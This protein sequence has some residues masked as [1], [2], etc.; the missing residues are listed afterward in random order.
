M[1]K[2]LNKAELDSHI[3]TIEGLV[4]DAGISVDIWLR[5][6]PIPN[7]IEID[8][9][10]DD[11]TRIQIT[12]GKVQIVATGSI[13]VFRRSNTMRPLTL[14]QG[15]SDWRLLGKYLNVSP[16]DLHLLVAW[17]AYTIGQPRTADAKYV[18]LVLQGGEGTGK[19]TLCKLITQIID[20]STLG[21]RKLPANEKDLAIATQAAHLLCFDNMRILTLAM[22]DAICV[23][24]TGG[25]I[26]SRQLYTDD[27]EHAL[28]LHG[29]L[30]LNGIHQFVDQPDLAQRCLPLR[31]MPIDR[32]ARKSERTI[33]SELSADLPAIMGGLY[34]LIAGILTALPKVEVTNPERMID[35]VE[36]IAAMEQAEGIPPGIYQALYSE[37]L[38]NGQ[39][40]TLM[41]N[42]LAAAILDFMDKRDDDKF[43]N[44]QWSGTP[45]AFLDA[46]NLATDQNL[47]RSRSWPQNAIAL[48]KR[49]PA[50][51]ASLLAQGI[52]IELSRG[53]NRTITLTKVEV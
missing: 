19:T 53:K 43:G 31:L 8:V 16:T 11:D 41:D 13:T 42:P 26:A 20:P 38:Q 18:I 23:A 15:R 7:G 52:R 47:G 28:R 40:D 25:S 32:Q 3:D 21:L 36:W 24:A 5:V 9:G 45:S 12:P 14:P 30:V 2:K 37:V 49:I 46:L 35:F 6:A 27:E 1:D 51:Q 22:A 44:I 4:L 34:E 48:S 33:T 39:L 10:D 17:I 29:P 50:L